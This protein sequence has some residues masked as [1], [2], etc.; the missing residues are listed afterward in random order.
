MKTT[1]LFHEV[2]YWFE[3]DDRKEVEQIDKDYIQEMIIKG[4]SSG[5]LVS[6]DDKVDTELFGWWQIKGFETQ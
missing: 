5:Q 3:L 2:E 6:Y 4:K 1:I